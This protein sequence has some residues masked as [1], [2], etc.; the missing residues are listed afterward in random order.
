M[1]KILCI[2]GKSGSGKS[3]SAEYIRK[4]H[5]I[6]MVES[7]TD[8]HPRYN[9]EKGHT[10]ISKKKF[11]AIKPED[12]IAFTEFG[13]KRYCCR[14]QDLQ[15]TNTYVIDPTGLKYL[16]DNYSNMYDIKS[17][18][19]HRSPEMKNISQERMD[20][21]EGKYFLPE[22]YYDY[23]ILNDGEYSDL[24]NSIDNVIKKVF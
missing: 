22:E 16:K 5:G 1:K 20:R 23:H 6:Y 21:D 3:L 12:M 17:L 9:G 24:F 15:D 2:I 18:Y 11:D 7:L 10:F 4:E 14:H 13:D 19:I 8:R